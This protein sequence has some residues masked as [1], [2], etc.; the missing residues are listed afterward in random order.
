MAKR[1]ATKEAALNYIDT[2]PMSTIRGMLAQFLTEEQPD[3][4]TITEEQ[5]NKFFKVR[6]KAIDA[7]TGEVVAERRGRKPKASK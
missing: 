6:G 7:A 3:K 4:I 2:L 5:L 1:F